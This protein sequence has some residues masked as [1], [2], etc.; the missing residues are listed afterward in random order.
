MSSGAGVNLM[1]YHLSGC[2][3]IFYGPG[4]TLLHPPIPPSIVPPSLPDARE[5]WYFSPSAIATGQ[6]NTSLPT[7]AILNDF[8]RHYEPVEYDA[9]ALVTQ[10]R[11]V[12]RSTAPSA[13]VQLQFRASDRSDTRPDERRA[14]LHHAWDARRTVHHPYHVPREQALMVLDG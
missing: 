1:S 11:R 3:L 7:G 10:H 13:D 4:P 6:S 2:S 9:P 5:L 8:I 14:P 12:R